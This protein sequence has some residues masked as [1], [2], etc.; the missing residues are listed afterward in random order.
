[1][2]HRRY[3]VTASSDVEIRVYDVDCTAF[4]KV[5]LGFVVAL[6][7]EIRVQFDRT[8]NQSRIPA[9]FKHITRRRKRN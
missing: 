9:E 8:S 2:L 3:L 1:M 7:P 4:E 6:N 5:A